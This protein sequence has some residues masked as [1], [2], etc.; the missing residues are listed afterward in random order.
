MLN[1]EQCKKVLNKNGK[2]YKEEEII[3]VHKVLYQI[4]QMDYN[5]FKK[6]NCYGKERNNIYQSINR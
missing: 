4:A 3:K 2:Q 5:F 1:I 6:E